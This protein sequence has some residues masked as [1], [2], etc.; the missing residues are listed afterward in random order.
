[1]TIMSIMVSQDSDLFQETTFTSASC[2]CVVSMQALAGFARASHI[3]I[4]LS[5][6]HD[7]KTCQT[8]KEDNENEGL[9]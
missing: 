4:V 6:E 1:M 5:T 7:A 2:A 8:K 3:R 9:S